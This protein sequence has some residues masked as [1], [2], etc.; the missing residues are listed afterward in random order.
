MPDILLPY[1]ICSNRFYMF[2]YVNFRITSAIYA[3]LCRRK[4]LQKTAIK[5]C[6]VTRHYRFNCFPI[7]LNKQEL[8]WELGC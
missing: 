7:E 8:A 1:M 6:C 3:N 2:K 5:C 4:A